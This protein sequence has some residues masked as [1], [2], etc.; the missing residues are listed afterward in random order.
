MCIM[1]LCVCMKL[2][3]LLLSSVLPSEPSLKL[4]VGSCQFHDYRL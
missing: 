4:Y 2:L 3:F 1:P